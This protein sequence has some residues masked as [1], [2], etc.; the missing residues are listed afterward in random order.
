MPGSRGRL[1]DDRLRHRGI[2]VNRGACSAR[3]GHLRTQIRLY[4][5]VLDACH[6]DRCAGERG[7]P[8]DR[9]ARGRACGDLRFSPAVMVAGTDAGQRG[10][11]IRG[12]VA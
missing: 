7:R 4:G 11:S 1:R 5:A 9:L 10:M 2:G 8:R 3:R 6:A 12:G